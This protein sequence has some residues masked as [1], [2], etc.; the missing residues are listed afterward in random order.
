MGVDSKEGGMG[1]VKR[2]GMGV[3]TEEGGNGSR[4]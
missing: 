2:V 4:Y 3:D 1:V